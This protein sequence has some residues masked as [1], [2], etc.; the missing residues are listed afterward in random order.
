MK[1]HRRTFLGSLLTF[2]TIPEVAKD[3]VVLWNP[4]PAQKKYL[5]DK[6][7]LILMGGLGYGAHAVLTNLQIPEYETRERHGTRRREARGR[8]QR[9]RRG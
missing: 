3:K 1:T 8:S 5:W 2:V 6:T 4:H 7:E 9:G